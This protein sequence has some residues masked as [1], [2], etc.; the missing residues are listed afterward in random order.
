MMKLKDLRG[1]VA[2]SFREIH[3]VDVYGS[4]INL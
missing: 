4:S 2:Q 3:I 1:H